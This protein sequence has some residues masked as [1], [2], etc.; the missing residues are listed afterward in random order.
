MGQKELAFSLPRSRNTR[1]AEK[2]QPGYAHWR[3]SRGRAE[4]AALG[5]GYRS[6][7]KSG[8]TLPRKEI[9]RLPSDLASGGG[10]APCK[11]WL[12]GDADIRASVPHD[13]RPR[14]VTVGAKPDPLKGCAVN[15]AEIVATGQSVPAPSGVAPTVRR[16]LP[17]AE[18]CFK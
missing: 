8:Q 5:N 4:K 18:V 6:R 1:M 15:G 3:F 10:T 17:K 7:V 13:F 11:A 2:V 14:A 12:Q 9:D 16:A